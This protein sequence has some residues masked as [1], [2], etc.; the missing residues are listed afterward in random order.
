MKNIT[1]KMYFSPLFFAD[2]SA[3]AKHIFTTSYV[4]VMVKKGAHI[5]TKKSS[6]NR[7]QTRGSGKP[8]T[9]HETAKANQ[10]GIKQGGKSGNSA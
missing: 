8:D 7:G 6:K 5:H 10:G 2:T 1:L 3:H 4:F 9:S